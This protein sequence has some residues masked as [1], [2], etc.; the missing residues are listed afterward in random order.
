MK[1]D[2]KEWYDGV[3]AGFAGHEKTVNL[4]NKALTYSAYVG[5]PLIL[6]WFWL[7]KRPP[8]YEMAKLVVIPA[9]SFRLLTAVRDK[10]DRPRP[11]ETHDI[12][13]IIKKDK[14]GHSFPSRHCFSMACISMVFMYVNRGLGRLFVNSMLRTD[15]MMIMGVTIFLAILIVTMNFLADVVYKLLD[16]RIDLS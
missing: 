10:I 7:T 11:Y 4:L 13:Q 1:K 2:Y 16:P 3:S 8:I 15:Y 9:V 5:Y 6:A 14:K 12:T